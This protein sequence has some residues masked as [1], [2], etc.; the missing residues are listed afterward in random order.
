MATA[1]KRRA[2]RLALLIE[3]PPRKLNDN[4]MHRIR[5]TQTHIHTLFS[6][7]DSSM[8]VFDTYFA[9]KF[10]LMSIKE[11]PGIRIYEDGNDLWSIDNRRLWIMRESGNFYYEGPYTEKHSKT[12]FMEFTSKHSSLH[13][14]SG[15]KVQFHPNDSSKC[16]IDAWNSDELDEHELSDHLG[17][18]VHQLSFLTQCPIH[19]SSSCNCLEVIP[20]KTRTIS[21]QQAL[22]KRCQLIQQ[23]AKKDNIIFSTKKRQLLNRF[24]EDE[25][26]LLEERIARL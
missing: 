24:D 11:L 10:G 6:N 9:I 18:T 20:D 22:S 26:E 2:E 25:E 7:H 3:K 16:C 1:E 17:L 5:F 4:D 21:L 12:R 14:A 13:G 19:R 23:L 8:D 15:E